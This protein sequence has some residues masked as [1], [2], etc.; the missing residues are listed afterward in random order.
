[1]ASQIGDIAR[2]VSRSRFYRIGSFSYRRRLWVILAWVLIL[3]VAFGPVKK[4]TDRLS[5]GGFEVPGSQSDQV[6]MLSEKEFKGQF[7]ITDL[8]VLRSSQHRATDRE[9][10]AA[11]RKVKAA[12]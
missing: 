12:M 10:R 6:K 1:M 3:F 5:Q 4:L 7:E 11:W 9:S 2:S 8:L